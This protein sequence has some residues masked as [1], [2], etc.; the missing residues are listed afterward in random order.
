VLGVGAYKNRPFTARRVVDGSKSGVRE[1][2]AESRAD[3]C[4][5]GFVSTL[6]VGCDEEKVA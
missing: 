4:G 1:Q 5:K 3:G 6:G 2:R